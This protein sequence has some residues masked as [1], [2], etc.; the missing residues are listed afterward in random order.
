ML[1]QLVQHDLGQRILLQIDNDVDAMAVRSVVNV[2]NLRQ[3]L[4]AHE[5]AELLEQALAVHLVGNLADHD[6]RFAIL[7]ILDR[8]FRTNGE[9]AAARLIRIENA[10]LPHDDAAG[11]EIGSRERGHELFSRD[12]GVVEHHA[13]RVDR[14]A[15][16]VRRDVR[17]HANRNAVR[18]VDQQVREARGKNL[19]L[20]EALIVVRLEINR[21]L[22]E[23]AQKLH[24]GLVEARLGVAH[25]CCG[26][27]VDRT[28]VAMAVN[29]GNPHREGLSKT[30]HRVIHCGVAVWMVLA[31]DVADGTR[32]LHMRAVRRITGLVHRIEDAAMNGLQAVAHIGKRSRDDNAHRI[33]QERRLHLFAQ[34]GTANSR[35]FATVC[36]LDDLSVGGRHVDEHRLRELLFGY[37]RAD[38]GSGGI[39][40]RFLFP[41][42]GLSVLLG[43]GKHLVERVVALG[44][45]PLRR[46]HVVIFCH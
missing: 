33:F 45:L 15:E 30:H 6:R 16:I 43:T 37:C 18:A 4:V 9:R 7:A 32:R 8:A 12:I 5:L 2:G 21:L 41:F 44:L 13:G 39:F 36:A 35:A 40:L 31:D 25:C 3:L 46:G 42:L 38:G 27:T 19:R 1:V 11:G 23:V 14:L 29:Q 24:S 10:L 20:L 17:R 22:V 26:V 34:V 28:E